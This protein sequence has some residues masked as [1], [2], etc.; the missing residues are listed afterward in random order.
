[1]SVMS[2]TK[3]QGWWALHRLAVCVPLAFLLAGA[4][5]LRNLSFY[6]RLCVALRNLDR[7]NRVL[8]DPKILAKR[9]LSYLRGDFNLKARQGS[10]NSL[11]GGAHEHALAVLVLQKQLVDDLAIQASDL[12]ALPCNGDAL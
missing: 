7:V 11:H 3:G 10:A 1:M 12:T 8:L 4:H 9:F 5:L 2:W 6:A